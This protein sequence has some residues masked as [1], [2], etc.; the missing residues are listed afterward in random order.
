MKNSKAYCICFIVC[1]TLLP[2]RS[3]YAVETIVRDVVGSGGRMSTNTEYQLVHT[4]GQPVINIVSN[5]DHIHE[6]GFWHLPWFFVTGVE[7]EPT[8]MA[9][10]LDQNFPN[11]FNPVTTIGFALSKPSHVR[12]RI[13]DVAGRLVMMAVDRQMDAGEHK[14]ELRAS[15]L[16]SGV[17]FYRLTADGFEE[18]RKMVV[19]R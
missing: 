15:G 9:C 11:P 4:V 6:Q 19:L 2:G 14:V 1:F 5:T 17:Y 13:Y 8:P 16:S 10:R 3:A 18:T 12:L 7:E